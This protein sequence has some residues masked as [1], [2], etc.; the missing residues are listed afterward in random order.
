MTDKYFVSLNDYLNSYLN[1]LKWMESC[2]FIPKF[3][4][5]HELASEGMR[6]QDMR[7]ILQIQHTEQ[8]AKEQNESLNRFLEFL[9]EFLSREYEIDENEDIFTEEIIQDL[10][11][12]VTYILDT[13]LP[14]LG[15]ISEP[16]I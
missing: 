15:V 11:V 2:F 8:S 12:L 6:I 1:G 16:E 13:V 4:L 9:P 5:I 10:I 14:S 3:K 7:N